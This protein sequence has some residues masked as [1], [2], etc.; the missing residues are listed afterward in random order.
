MYQL[1]PGLSIKSLSQSGLSWSLDSHSSLH[2]YPPSVLHLLHAAYKKLQNAMLFQT[3]PLVCKADSTLSK[4]T[5]L[6]SP[7]VRFTCYSL[8]LHSMLYLFNH[9][10]WILYLSYLLVFPTKLFEGRYFITFISWSSGNHSISI[11]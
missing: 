5:I 9:Y 6:I 1:P 8:V 4:R 11:C 10:L 7:W 3:T 2:L